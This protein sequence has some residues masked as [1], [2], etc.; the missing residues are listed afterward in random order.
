MFGGFVRNAY[1][2]SRKFIV[3]LKQNA[4]GKSFFQKNI[5]KKLLSW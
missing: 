1:F 4:Y 5:G 3:E 2:C